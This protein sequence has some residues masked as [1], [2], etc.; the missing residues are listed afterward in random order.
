MSWVSIW[1]WLSHVVE[2]SRM[3]GFLE[4]AMGV[5]VAATVL[6]SITDKASNDFDDAA[7]KFIEDEMVGG[8]ELD[9]ETD[10]YKSA[11]EDKNKHLDVIRKKAKGARR[12]TLF[13]AVV[14]ALGLFMPSMT[15]AGDWGLY[16]ALEIVLFLGLLLPLPYLVHKLERKSN[17]LLDEFTK[18]CER[19]I[20]ALKDANKDKQKPN[21]PGNLAGATPSPVGPANPNRRRSNQNNKRNN[22]NRKR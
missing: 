11:I 19:V 5:N 14:A 12:V 10:T 6:K 1:D 13:L 20:Q 17:A 9:S 8:E 22:R 15:E 18:N 16:R 2:F 7:E 21:L 4:V 3:S